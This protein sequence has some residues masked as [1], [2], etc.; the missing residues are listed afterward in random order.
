MKIIHSADIHLDSPFTVS[1]PS[2]AEKRRH[3]LRSAFSNIVLYAK[4]NSVDLFIISGDLFDREC[5]TK[6]T[7]LMLCREMASVPTCRFVIA[8]G[9][10]DPY[11]KNSA[12]SLVSFPENVYIFKSPEI[13]HFEFDDLG[14]RVYGYAFTSDTYENRPLQN[15]KLPKDGYNGINILAAHCDFDCEKSYYA[16]VTR[17]DLQNSGFDYAAFGHIHKG[18]AE[19]EKA[20]DTYFAYSGCLEG[21]S[22]DETGPKGALVGEIEK[23]RV[24][25][26]KVRF[27]LKR[28]E[29]ISVDV[30]GSHTFAD[31]A[32]MLSAACSEFDSDTILRV[33]LTGITS[34]EFFC[35]EVSVK[36]VLSFLSGVE[37]RDE[38]LAILDMNNL[39]TE[40]TLAGEFYRSL[41]DKLFSEDQE[42]KRIAYGALK[43]GLRAING[44][45]INL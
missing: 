23:G 10:H 4:T 21:R 36:Q 26:K 17:E 12:Y 16:P 3:A 45:D 32:Q 5:V 15:F 37:V 38:T 7:T 25:L 8:P 31:C 29:K 20:G 2:Q 1:D 11:N 43:Y 28:Y 39:K 22:F 41:E 24:S 14:C 42:E 27:S 33:T 9:N 13:S 19:L 6:D 40:N 18:S 30:S 44:M 34:P 35:D